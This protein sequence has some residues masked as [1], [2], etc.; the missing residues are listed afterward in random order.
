[1]GD[2]RDKAIPLV[3][4]G[5]ASDEVTGHDWDYI[6]SHL[7]LLEHDRQLAAVTRVVGWVGMLAVVCLLVWMLMRKPVEEVAE[8]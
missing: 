5:V 6:L 3:S 7:G 8:A 2:A 4:P 1:M